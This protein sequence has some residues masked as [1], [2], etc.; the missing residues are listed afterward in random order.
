MQQERFDVLVVGS[1]IGGLGAAALL[2]HRGYR[3][4]VVERM[5]RVGGRMSTEEYEGFKLP[6]GALAIH[7]GDE[8]DEI[9]KSVGIEVELLDVPPLFYRLA[10]KDYEMP[11]KGSIST[12]F[13]I[14]GKLEVDRGKLMG[15]FVKAGG[16]EKI[17]GAFRK[18]I[19]NPEKELTTFKDWLLQ[20]T[21]NELAHDIFD[22]ITC[23]LL[24]CRSYEVS[25]SAM[26][27]WFVRM[28]GARDVG[29][30][31]YG[32]LVNMEKLADVVKRNGDVWINC[33][34][35][36]ILVNRGTAQGIVVEKDGNEVE[37][38]GKVV[39]S[40]AGTRNTVDLAGEEN[41]NEGYLRT[42]RLRHR[43]HP[44]IV[45]FIASDRPLWPEDGSPA[46]LMLTGTRRV[47]SFIPLTSIAPEL[48]PPGQHLLFGLASPVSSEVD[49]DVDEELRQV[50][51]DIKEQLPGFEKYGRILK[52]DP[53]NR[54]HPFTD[55]K[56]RPGLGMP[57]ETPVKNL[58]NVGDAILGPGLAGTTGA[59]ESALRVVEMIRKSLK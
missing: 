34:A 50:T 16:K 53:R 42:L 3:T 9:F 10:G 13:D 41:F 48:A 11:T 56:T 59:A 45:C 33:P 21:D 7:R 52:L 6:T 47:K 14:L 5:G 58:Y 29:V 30:A 8:V 19:A 18:S 22:T 27:A 35:K 40:N 57:P 2:A 32:N 24:G 51:L 36:R 1:G 26:F 17:M 55:V 54:D 15:A 46:I 31:P 44:C 43:P 39:V 37:I 25:A 12:M 23:A 4:L 38:P 28:G 20:Y 49:M